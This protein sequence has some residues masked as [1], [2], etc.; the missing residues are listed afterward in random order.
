MG[1]S[2]VYSVNMRTSAPATIIIGWR[3]HARVFGGTAA[4][5]AR[6]CVHLRAAGQGRTINAVV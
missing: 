4:G 6:H 3:Q 1:V 2:L 5:S